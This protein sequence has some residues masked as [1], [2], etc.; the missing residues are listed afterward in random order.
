MSWDGL[1]P[2]YSFF[3]LD[4]TK[5]N[6]KAEFMK[7]TSW[8]DIYPNV[9]EKEEVIFELL[10][11]FKPSKFQLKF[12][13][14]HNS[15]LYRRFSKLE[16]FFYHYLRNK[17]TAECQPFYIGH[18]RSEEG[19]KRIV[20]EERLTFLKD[21]FMHMLEHINSDFDDDLLTDAVQL[22]VK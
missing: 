14:Q 7:V 18:K 16:G 22:I 2:K 5:G 3:V 11:P 19:D 15:L 13:K 4:A 9:E 10:G 8:N 1:A 12:Y 21:W 20:T 17:E 6:E